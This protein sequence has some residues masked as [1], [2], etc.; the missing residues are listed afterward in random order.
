[1]KKLYALVF[2]VALAGCVGAPTYDPVEYNRFVEVAG[3]ITIASKYCGDDMAP[4]LIPSAV[5]HIRNQLS[6]VDIYVTHRPDR[7]EVKQIVTILDKELEQMQQTY[8]S[9]KPSVAY[10]KGKF[11]ILSV[12]LTKV[13]NTLG[14]LSQQ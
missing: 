5:E 4:L 3:S 9:S 7:S 10:C 2:A 11:Q 13:L 6:V 1:M 8:Q 14:G 12:S